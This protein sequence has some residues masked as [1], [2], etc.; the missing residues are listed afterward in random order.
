MNYC[1]FFPKSRIG[2]E[3]P[4]RSDANVY[5]ASKYIEMHMSFIKDMQLEYDYADMS[6]VV[7]WGYTIIPIP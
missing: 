1:V 5:E 2:I 4:I 6:L 7:K 3:I